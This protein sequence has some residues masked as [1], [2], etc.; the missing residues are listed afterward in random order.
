MPTQ[1]SA[2]PNNGFDGT[3]HIDTRAWLR[4]PFTD[5]TVLGVMRGNNNQ[6][7]LIFRRTMRAGAGADEMLEQANAQP[8]RG[9]FRQWS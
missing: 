5:T 3:E 2:S 8:S 1:D 7:Q 9:S 4:E 6:L